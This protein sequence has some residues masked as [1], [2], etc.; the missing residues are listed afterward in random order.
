M[1]SAAL[2]LEVHE[3]IL[4][5]KITAVS[6]TSDTLKILVN[7]RGSNHLPLPDIFQSRSS[8]V[9]ELLEDRRS[10]SHMRGSSEIFLNFFR[11]DNTEKCVR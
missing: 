11:M 6:I 1:S 9:S 10:M 8:S 7:S 2:V 5:G 4:R 3:K